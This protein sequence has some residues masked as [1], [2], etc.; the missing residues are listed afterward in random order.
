MLS[1]AIADLGPPSQLP[2]STPAAGKAS[3]DKMGNV[4][5]AEVVAGG[6][7]RASRIGLE[8]QR[9]LPYDAWASLGVKLGERASSSCWWLG[10]WLAF[11]ERRYR[12]YEQALDVTRLEHGTLRNYAAVARRFQL[13][14]R[15]DNLSFQHHAT[16]CSAPDEVQDRWLDLAIEHAWPVRELRRRMRQTLAPSSQAD[17]VLRIGIAVTGE[18]EAGW[19]EA[20]NRAGCP[21][22]EW[23]VRTLTAAAQGEAPA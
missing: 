6:L 17:R 18:V 3:A 1:T 11:G 23:I 8:I 19:R 10:D 22:E 5:R 20:S 21:L 2:Q 12:R 15:R 13:S 7:V 16:V 4:R 14:R 9:D